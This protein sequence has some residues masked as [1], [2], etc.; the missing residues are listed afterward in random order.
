MTFTL[1]GFTDG[2]GMR[3]FAFQGLR[4]DHSKST[5]M[6]DADVNLARKHDIRLQELPLICLRLLESFGAD[7]PSEAITLTE[8]QMI[9]VQEEARNAAE[10]KTR[11]APRRPA[12]EPGQAWRNLH[13]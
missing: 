10:K 1:S 9:A 6:V 11:K 5:V 4:G 13:L 7:E 2:H 3:R 8:D 12:P